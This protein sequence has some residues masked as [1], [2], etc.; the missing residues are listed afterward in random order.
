LIPALS[1]SI[2]DRMI[3]PMLPREPVAFVEFIAGVCLPVYDDG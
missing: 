1:A 3:H 2:L